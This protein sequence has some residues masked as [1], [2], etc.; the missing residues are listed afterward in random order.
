MFMK[1]RKRKLTALVLILVLVSVMYG[2]QDSAKGTVKQIR[3]M[4]TSSGKPLLVDS[5]S[6]GNYAYE[7][8]DEDTRLV[9]DE[10]VYA[11]QNRK[12]KVR[13][14]TTD[15]SVMEKAYMAVRY[16]YCN[17][18]WLEK[19]SYVTYRKGKNITAIDITPVYSVSEKEQESLQAK[20]ENEAKH[21]LADAPVDGTDYEKALYV[22]ETLIEQV[23]Y[24]ETSENN[25]NILSVFL[26]HRTICQG[27]AYATQYLLE[28]LG[29]PCTTVVGT[30]EGENHAWNLIRLDG[31]YYYMDTTWGNSQ[32][33]Y[34]DSGES[35]QSVKGKKF[36]DYDYMA[37]D[38]ETLMDTHQADPTIPLPECTESKDNYYV[39]EGKY[40]AS[41]DPEKIGD[42]IRTA[43]EQGENQVQIKFSDM[44]LYEQAFQYFVENY[45]IEDYCSGLDTLR[46]LENSGNNVLFLQFSSEEE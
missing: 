44:E 32:Y 3:T 33:M 21:M 22:Y 27:Y 45:H 30:A 42:V 19:F 23:D 25:Q 31:A 8:L 20:I 38:T 16:D 12:E 7:T 10:I 26:N 13:I 40:F 36:I 4:I 24:D 1:N 6:E 11:I 5:V 37:V 14:A 41:W 46:Y 28:R 17:F 9:Y 2:C 15:V 43:Y 29:I 39:H 35:A 34:R 18:F